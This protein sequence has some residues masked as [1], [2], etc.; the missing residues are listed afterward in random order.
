MRWRRAASSASPRCSPA[1]RRSSCRRFTRRCRRR[2]CSP[3]RSSKG[4]RST[5]GSP[6]RPTPRRGIAPARRSSSSTWRRCGAR[7]CTT[8]IRTRGTTSSSP[9]GAWRSSTSAAP[10]TSTARAPPPRASWCAPSSR[11]RDRACGSCGGSTLPC[12]RVSSCFCCVCSSGSRR[13]PAASARTSSGSASSSAPRWR[14]PRRSRRR[15][16]RRRRSRRGRS[17]RRRAAAQPQPPT[18][19]PPTPQPPT[20]QPPTAQPQPQPPAPQPPTPQPP[21]AQPPTPQLQPPPPTASVDTGAY[22]LVLVD[23]GLHLIA[24]IRELRDAT[25]RELRDVKALVDACPQTLE[26]ALPRSDADALR[27][28]LE[29][30]GARVDLRRAVNAG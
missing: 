9:T 20:P 2:A 26:L 19:Q 4:R 3:P 25:G 24:V 30:A 27:H 29:A 23:P 11:R 28:R 15:R 18:P 7:G 14:A 16:S 8:A 6:A 1:T 17:R 13:W 21:T 10:P 5:T 12:S 22:D